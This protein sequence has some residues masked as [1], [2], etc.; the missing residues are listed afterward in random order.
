MIQGGDTIQHK[1]TYLGRQWE[2]MKNKTLGRWTIQYRHMWGDNGK[3]LETMGD[4]EKHVETTGDKNR[5]DNAQR[6]GRTQAL[7][8]RG[9][10]FTNK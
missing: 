3:H 8:R 1:H 6:L 10:P 7:Q 5:I 9:F 4:N 2:T